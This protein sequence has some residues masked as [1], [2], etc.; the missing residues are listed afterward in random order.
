MVAVHLAVGGDEQELAAAG[1]P[2]GVAHLGRQVVHRKARG[3]HGGVAVE[4]HIAA[5]GRVVE[6]DAQRAPAAKV[7]TVRLTRVHLHGGL[8][9]RQDGEGEAL[10]GQQ[11]QRLLV[12]C[13]LG[14]PQA[15]RGVAVAPVEVAHAPG[16]LQAFLPRRGERQD[17]VMVGL[18]EGIAVARALVCGPRSGGDEL[19]SCGVRHLQP[20]GQGRPEVEAHVAKVSQLGVGAVALVPDLLV[21]VV[22]RGS[23][24]LAV[25]QARKRVQARGLIEMPVC[26][27][28]NVLHWID[29]PDRQRQCT[30]RLYLTVSYITALDVRPAR[31]VPY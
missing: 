15:F 21:K 19:Q 3:V 29:S 24:R 23:S 5:E 17:R 20:R 16:D 14:Q 10:L 28:I 31:C 8:P 1:A 22:V 26:A 13:R 25:D 4:G 30:D 6:E 2:P 9:R 11:L 18:G 7:E 27:E 12:G